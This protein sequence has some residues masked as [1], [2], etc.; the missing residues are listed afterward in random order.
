MDPHPVGME[1]ALCQAEDTVPAI[2]GWLGAG[3]GKAG[4]QQGARRGGRVVWWREEIEEGVTLD[5]LTISL[6]KKNIRRM[7][8]EWPDQRS[9]SD[10]PSARGW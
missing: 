9:N 3:N 5:F 10:H 4:E 8:R 7:I 6:G 1:P 2:A